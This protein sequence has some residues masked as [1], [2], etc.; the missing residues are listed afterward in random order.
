MKSSSR[1]H[2]IYQFSACTCNMY[3]YYEE[4]YYCLMYNIRF[5]VRNILLYFIINNATIYMNEK[6]ET[7]TR[8]NCMS[9]YNYL[10]ATVGQ[11][12]TLFKRTSFESQLNC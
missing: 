10:M 9:T 2:G 6:S 1:L 11:L 5:I 8:S 4:Q 12:M 3:P 7:F